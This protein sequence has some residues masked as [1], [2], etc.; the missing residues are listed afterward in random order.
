MKEPFINLDQVISQTQAL[1]DMELQ[2]YLGSLRSTASGSGLSDF[3]QTNI[4]DTVTSVANIKRAKYVNIRDQ[5][6]QADNGVTSAAYYLARTQDL[7]NLAGDIEEVTAAQLNSRD[8]YKNKAKRQHEINEW[9][10]FNKLET[11]Y[12]MQVLFIGITFICALVFLKMNLLISS[13][14]LTILSS[15]VMF[16]II[17][18]FIIKVRYTN[19]ARDGRYWHK[20]RFPKQKDATGGQPTCG[21]PPVVT[22][23][24]PVEPTPWCPSR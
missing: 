21:T 1:A 22:P 6:T 18:M 10:N 5:V 9:A 3:V 15:I 8:L 14:V 23:P 24:E 16:I 19:V 7:N 17:L 12:F 20:A 4:N 2:A 11:L 13:S